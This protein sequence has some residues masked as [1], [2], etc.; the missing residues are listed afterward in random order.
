VKSEDTKVIAETARVHV[1]V[2]D[3]IALRV[4][5]LSK[6]FLPKNSTP[7]LAMSK[8]S[9]EV[10]SQEVLALLGPSGCGKSTLLRVIGGL[11]T[12]Y[13]GRV[14]WTSRS[15]E[16]GR[17]ATATVFQ[18][19]S[20]L[21]WLNVSD[22][23]ALGLSGLKLSKQERRD[24]VEQY[25]ALV[26]L[27]HF[28]SS[29]P[30]ELSGGMRQRVAIARALAAE[31]HVLLMDEPLAA[32][33]AQTRIVMQSEL[34]A[35]W[36]RTGSTVVYVT[37]DIEEAVTLA[38]RVIVMTARPGRIKS[39]RSVAIPRIG[40]DG[41]LSEPLELRAMPEFGQLALAL[42]SDLA[43]EVGSALS[44]ERQVSKQ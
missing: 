16:A 26:G 41:R 31:P 5:E 34:V 11:D 17:L 40:Q 38:D 8:V 32:L 14:E 22:N 18:Q 12:D 35:I 23:I 21:P 4:E 27:E 15:S 19:D 30:H 20:T 25:S 42:W 3:E 28:R 24:R 44:S 29:Y 36:K 9:V 13:Q 2:G 39:E 37:H 1:P 7:V 10:R 43:E 33:D 6:L